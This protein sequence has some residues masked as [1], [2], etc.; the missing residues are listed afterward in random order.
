M[1][2]K[3]FFLLTLLTLIYACV[4][5]LFN[6]M[7]YEQFLSFHDSMSYYNQS[8]KIAEGVSTPYSST[9]F[10]PLFL[11]ETIISFTDFNRESGVI[12]IFIYFY[13]FVV[14]L[15]IFYIKVF[16]YT[17][18][19]ALIF[20]IPFFF[21][22]GYLLRFGGIAD[23][24]MDL[25]FVFIFASVVIWYE[26]LIS[27]NK[28]SHWIVFSILFSIMLLTRAT[29]IIYILLVL[30]PLFLFDFKILFKKEMLFKISLSIF[31]IL[32]LSAWFYYVQFDYLYY[33]YFIWNFDANKRIPL[34]LSVYH[35]EFVLKFLGLLPFIYVL[36]LKTV[37]TKDIKNFFSF[38]LNMRIIRYILIGIIPVSFMI[39]KGAGLNPFVALPS[40][41]GIMLTFIIFMLPKDS[42]AEVITKIKII[43]FT[44][45][46]V[47]F[48]IIVLKE[49]YTNH[50]AFFIG[51]KKELNSQ[52]TKLLENDNNISI[53]ILPFAD[54]INNDIL[55]NYLMF[56]KG[57]R[58]T[59]VNSFIKDKNTIKINSF[60]YVN[61]TEF[62][63]LDGKNDLEKV[64]SYI[65]MMLN[66]EYLII[67]TLST[68]EYLE[69]YRFHIYINKYSTTFVKKLMADKNLKIA[70][71][72][73]KLNENEE[74]YIM[75]NNLNRN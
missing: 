72:K 11:A 28:N 51:E 68:A 6:E 13:I 39:L 16:K 19:Y 26:I 75:K 32:A 18:A 10:F 66:S 42:L 57:Y 12:V 60:P 38:T 33:Y 24:R 67:P 25:L 36:I 49:A 56:D 45:I 21:L 35:L 71:K 30:L 53:S 47:V 41:F 69:K 23:F 2:T 54:S 29:S 55:I 70:S 44:L 52:L 34:E 43:L 46:T 50:N 5:I 31:L 7:Y 59:K 73:F 48:F 8:M 61:E 22:H 20:V 14:S 64:D 15:Y 58:P 27:E 4:F 9:V 3:E 65:N 40:C 74:F 17:K 62:P 1:L 63:T 37:F